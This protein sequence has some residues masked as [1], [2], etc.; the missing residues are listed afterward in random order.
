METCYL[1]KIDVLK[2]SPD[3]K[4]IVNLKSAKHVDV[5]CEQKEH[6]DNV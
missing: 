5:G 1:I 4:V 6:L 3:S 2:K